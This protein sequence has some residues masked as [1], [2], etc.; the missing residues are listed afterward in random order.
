MQLVFELGVEWPKIMYQ[1]RLNVKG[2]EPRDS[3]PKIE[4]LPIRS[5]INLMY[6]F[7]TGE[8]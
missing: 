8:Y 4:Q 7:L 2:Q 6:L 1:R 5:N 3:K